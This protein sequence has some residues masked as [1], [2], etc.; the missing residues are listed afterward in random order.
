MS[1]FLALLAAEG[2]ADD[3]IGQ[4][5][6]P[7]GTQLRAGGQRCVA[8]ITSADFSAI[9]T[10]G[11]AVFPEVIVGITDASITRSRAM[12]RTRS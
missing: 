5:H 2:L 4:Q 7:A 9:I 6:D 3:E 10:T 11:E 12:P 8:R 1:H